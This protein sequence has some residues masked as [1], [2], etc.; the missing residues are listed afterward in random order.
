M[1]QSEINIQIGDRAPSVYFTEL[2]D[3]A[4][5]GVA[6]FGAIRDLPTLR[7]NMEA[8]CIPGG[9]ENMTVEDYD[10]FLHQRRHLMAEKIRM[11][12]QSL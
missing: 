4:Q 6:R 8:H 3:S 10:S 7:Q 1:M 12:Y 5:N 9:V 11:Y 2:F